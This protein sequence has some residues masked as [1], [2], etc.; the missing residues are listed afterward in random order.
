MKIAFIGIEGKYNLLHVKYWLD[1]AFSIGIDAKAYF[2]SI[3]EKGHSHNYELIKLNYSKD[4][5]QLLI[6]KLKNEGI[7]G[8]FSISDHLSILASILNSQL[9]F[10]FSNVKSIQILRSKKRL[11]EHILKYMPENFIPT[12][13]FDT[14]TKYKHILKMSP[15]WIFKLDLGSGSFDI[16]T[17]ETYSQLL[18]NLSTIKYKTMGDVVIQPYLEELGIAADIIVKNSKL[19]IIYVYNFYDEKYPGIGIKSRLI[20][21]NDALYSERVYKKIIDTLTRFVN[22]LQLENYHSNFQLYIDKEERIYILDPNTR[23]SMHMWNYV[24]NIMGLN[25]YENSILAFLNEKYNFSWN[26]IHIYQTDNDN[27][28]NT[29]NVDNIC[30]SNFNNKITDKNDSNSVRLFYSKNIET[31]IN[32]KNYENIK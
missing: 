24:R 6:N 4:N 8:V 18:N 10:P 21:K 29:I 19:E 3:G 28:L 15:R 23:P 30:I 31:L 11:S 13:S 26:N 22:S 12:F 5:I 25:Y 27:K 20:T 16:G 2:C 9:D 1:A 32:I 14:I 7:V 17:F